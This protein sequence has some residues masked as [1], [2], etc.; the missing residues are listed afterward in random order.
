MHLHFIWFYYSVGLAMALALTLWFWFWRFF[1][2]MPCHCVSFSSFFWFY[3]FIHVHLLIGP[4]SLSVQYIRTQVD[5]WCG[6]RAHTGDNIQIE[7]SETV[8]AMDFFNAIAIFIVV[9]RTM[10]HHPCYVAVSVCFSHCV[11]ML[12]NS[13]FFG[14]CCEL[15]FFLVFLLDIFHSFA[16]RNFA[17]ELLL[18][19]F[20]YA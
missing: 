10:A 6:G 15:H 11:C 12:F 4:L 18:V 3:S 20:I 16:A 2:H 19:C 9:W 1:S 17:G 13:Y 7:C 8:S 5:W 14:F